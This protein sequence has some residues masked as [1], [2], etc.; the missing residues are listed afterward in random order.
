M[1]EQ[2]ARARLRPMIPHEFTAK[3]SPPREFVGLTDSKHVLDRP[4]LLGQS[5]PHVVNRAEATDVDSVDHLVSAHQ[6]P[7]RTTGLTPRRAWA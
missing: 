1:I 4:S 6:A 5:R 7:V 3:W 2:S